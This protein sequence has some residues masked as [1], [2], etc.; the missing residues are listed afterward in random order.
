MLHTRRAFFAL[1]AVLAIASVA[2]SDDSSSSAAGSTATSPGGDSGGAAVA[3]TEKDF[4]IAIDPTEVAVGEVTFTINNEGPSAHEFVVIESDTAPG[5]LP[6]EDGLVSEDGVT[7]IGE[8]EDVAPSTTVPLTLELE[9]GQYVI[10]CNLPG[11]YEQGMY[12]GLKA[13]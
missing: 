5:D 4:S 12:T 3:A 8:A 7:V 11:H 6:V 2:C 13:T 10:I 1:V 9:A